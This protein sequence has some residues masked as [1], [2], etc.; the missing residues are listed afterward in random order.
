FVSLRIRL[1]QRRTVLPLRARVMGIY[2]GFS[3]AS[4]PI[5][6]MYL[7][8]N[9]PPATIG[10]R[11]WR[12]RLPVLGLF[13]CFLPAWL[14]LSLPV[15]VTR[16]RF[17]DALCVFILG[18]VAPVP[19]STRR[20]KWPL[21][22]ASWERKEPLAAGQGLLWSAAARPRTPRFEYCSKSGRR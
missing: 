12:L 18:I 3:Q 16:K 22:F 7:R 11:R 21:R 15:A 9:L 10:S 8:A 17:F 5:A 2:S 14:R 19:L 13:R 20:G 4:P 6:L 1:R